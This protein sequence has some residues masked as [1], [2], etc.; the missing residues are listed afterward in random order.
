MD[1]DNEELG[2]SSS[3]YDTLAQSP[4]DSDDGPPPG[5]MFTASKETMDCD[6]EDVE[7]DVLNL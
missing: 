2:Q 5:T 4:E 7:D 1:E 6:R 3:L